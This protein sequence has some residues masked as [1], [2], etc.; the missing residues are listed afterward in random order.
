[1][2]L[3]SYFVAAMAPISLVDRRLPWLEHYLET[4]LT[5][6]DYNALRVA[7]DR[8]NSR[9]GKFYHW[10]FQK[11]VI[12]SI[13]KRVTRES[14]LKMTSSLD[15]SNYDALDASLLSGR[16]V[17]LALPHHGLY[18]NSIV[19]LI[20]RVR[21]SRD[22]YIF[23]GDPATHPGNE[24]FDALCKR[25]WL[26]D[27]ESR[28]HVLY[29]N[30]SGMGKA[31]RALQAGAAVIIMPD[32]FKNELDTFQIPFCGRA[33]NIMLGTAVLARKTNASILPVVCSPVGLGMAFATKMGPCIEPSRPFEGEGDVDMDLLNYR[34]ML[35]VFRFYESTMGENIVY[36]QFARQV[37]AHDVQFPVLAVDALQA[38]ADALTADARLHVPTAFTTHSV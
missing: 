23:Y 38:A 29:D 15:R 24:V 6:R 36:W 20:E 4:P 34:T 5:E 19:S 3:P 27:P 16:G 14:V 22:I 11:K 7:C 18:I 31:L 32:V 33:I 8:S 26:N 17:I 10:Y 28:V 37:Y 21:S 1:M 13:W 30:R 25:V 2:F 35:Q 12:S 9:F